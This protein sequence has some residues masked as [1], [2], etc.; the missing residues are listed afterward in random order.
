MSASCTPTLAHL[1]CKN[2]VLSTAAT[3]QLAHAGKKM[4]FS[5]LPKDGASSRIEP[6]DSVVFILNTIANNIAQRNANY[7]TTFQ[8]VSISISDFTNRLVNPFSQACFNLFILFKTFTFDSLVFPLRNFWR[9]KHVARSEA[10]QNRRNNAASVR[11]VL[12]YRSNNM[13]TFRVTGHD[14]VTPTL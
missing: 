10:K 1:Q 6:T 11:H 9:Q 7:L 13:N 5:N 12:C 8:N 2:V 14:V 3:K 4:R